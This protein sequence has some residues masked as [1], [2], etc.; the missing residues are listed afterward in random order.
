MVQ[1]YKI[2]SK[3]ANIIVF[4]AGLITYIGKDTL[5][6]ILPP[7]YANWAPI[8]VLLAGYIVVQST[9]N[10][11]VERAEKIAV[12]NYEA[13]NNTTIDPAAEYETLHTNDAVGE[14]DVN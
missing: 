10:T 2:K 12:I 8:I 3:T 14:D 9:E 1:S 5:A 4:A 6:Q 11:R 13:E 7:E